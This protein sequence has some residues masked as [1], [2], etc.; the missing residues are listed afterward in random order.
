VPVS[1]KKKAF[2]TALVIAL[3][4]D[5]AID[6]LLIGIAAAAGPSA[7]PMMS[8]SLAVEMSFL[9]LTLATA[10]HGH[11]TSKS[12]SASVLG[13]AVLVIG[14]AAG[15]LLSDALSHSPAMFAGLLGFGTS[16]LLFM[17]AE[18]LLLEAH[19]EGDHIWWVDLQLYGGLR[20][21]PGW[22]IYQKI[23]CMH[24]C[25]YDCRIN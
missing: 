19:E 17:V 23:E 1:A 21:C 13:P 15:G 8:A 24:A 22:Q 12:F 16:A 20:F 2:P 18:E 3:A 14:A 9:G 4:I 5:S 7:G 10:L 25:D 6:G 11:P